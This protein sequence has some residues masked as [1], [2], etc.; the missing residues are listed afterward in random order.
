L[1][2][3]WRTVDMILAPKNVCKRKRAGQHCQN[4]LPNRQALTPPAPI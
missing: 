4:R 2:A 1:I 3:S